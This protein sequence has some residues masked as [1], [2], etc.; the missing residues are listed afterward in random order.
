MASPFVITHASNI[1]VKTSDVVILSLLRRVV[2]QNTNSKL[3]P[4]FK[5]PCLVAIRNNYTHNA[6]EDD[7]TVAIKEMVLAGSSSEAIDEFFSKQIP[8]W[9][10]G[11]V[12]WHL[13]KF[14]TALRLVPHGTYYE[15]T[16]RYWDVATLHS[17]AFLCNWRYV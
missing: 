7:H 8:S 12:N 11:Q 1:S 9:N 6:T 4:G 15:P 3:H 2:L 5:A 16:A 10:V 14:Y 13:L 17:K